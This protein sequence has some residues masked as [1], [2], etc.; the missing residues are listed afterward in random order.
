VRRAAARAALTVTVLALAAALFA[1]AAGAAVFPPSVSLHLNQGRYKVSV[2]NFGETVVL[3]VET[4]A[5]KSQRHVAATSYVVHGTATESR[6]EATFGKLGEIAMRFHPSPNRS[7]EKPNRNCRGFDAF[8]VRRGTWQ[9]QLRFRGE[10]DY[11]VLDRQ[12]VRGSVETIAPKCRPLWERELTE[13]SGADRAA[14][15]PVT[16]LGAAPESG[17]LPLIRPSQEPGLG[18]EVPVL[19]DSWREGVDAAEFLGG[20]GREGGTLY[21]ATEEAEGRLAIFRAARAEAGPKAVTAD[22]ALTSAKL[23]GVAPFHGSARYRA[24]P[25]GTRTWE[26]NLTVSFPGIS[27]YRLTD[28]PFHPSLQL[29]PELLVGLVGIFA[30]H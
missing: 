10:G 18:P 27:R 25:D 14:S 29:F 2:G 17:S 11:L 28:E 13:G 3:A 8:V 4:G 19:E 12:R 5:L 24:A 16:R 15:G 26:G 1:S 30:A 23:T 7:W 22:R 6:I 20:G 9:G 21:A